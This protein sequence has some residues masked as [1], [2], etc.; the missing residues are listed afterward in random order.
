[1]MTL[2]SGLECGIKNRTDLE[3]RG[4]MLLEINF[5]RRPFFLSLCPQPPHVLCQRE[6]A[7]RAERRERESKADSSDW[8]ALPTGR[9]APICREGDKKGA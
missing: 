3:T 8:G 6:R 4:G 1:M 7:R 9:G 5:G 2:M